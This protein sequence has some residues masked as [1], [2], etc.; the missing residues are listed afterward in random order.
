MARVAIST[1]VIEDTV[2]VSEDVEQAERLRDPTH[3]RSYTE[4]EWRAFFGGAG[5]DVRE[6]AF[7]EKRRSVAEWLARTGCVGADA[8]RVRTL[9]GERIEGE[10]YV[11]TKI[12]L[13][14]AKR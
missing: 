1:V 5:L 13:R 2:Y 3:V 4:G 6:I 9:L 8:D 7:V 12:L 10:D 11:D 14:G